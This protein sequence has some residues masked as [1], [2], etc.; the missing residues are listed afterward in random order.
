[1]WLTSSGEEKIG[2]G[3]SRLSDPRGQGGARVLVK[4]YFDGLSRL[5][6]LYLQPRFRL[7]VRS[8]DIAHFEAED[9]G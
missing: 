6:L 4:F 2:L 8:A 5:L 9:V 1:M 3:L 7:Q